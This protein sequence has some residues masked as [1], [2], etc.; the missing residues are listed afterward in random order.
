MCFKGFKPDYINNSN[1]F[2]NKLNEKI[3]KSSPPLKDISNP[4]DLKN[5]ISP[6]FKNQD[7][8]TSNSNCFSSK[9]L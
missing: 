1:F 2:Q 3:E 9:E 7:S 6:K 4:N 8:I 5:E